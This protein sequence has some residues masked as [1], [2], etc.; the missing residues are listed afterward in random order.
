MSESLLELPNSPVEFEQQLDE[1]LLRDRPALRKM[2]FAVRKRQSKQEPCDQLLARLQKRLTKSQTIVAHKRQHVPSIEFPAN[3][4]VSERRE[5]IA[6]VISRNQVVVLAGET[7]SGKTTQLPKICLELGRG[8]NGLIGHTQP[9]RIAASTVASRIAEELKVELGTAVGYQVR[10]SDNSNEH[11]YIKL[12]TDGIL[13]AEIQNDPLLERYDTLIIDEA[14]E[15]SLNIDFLLGYIKQILPKRPD[16]K[17]I[18]TSATIDLK[19]FSEHFNNAPIVEVSGRT[20]PVEVLYRPWQGEAEDQNQA[21]LEAIEEILTLP[22]Q[23]SGDILVFLSGERDIREAANAIRKADLPHIEVLP[24]YARLSLAEQN[25][26]FQQHR[27]RRIVL[28]TNVA[29][30][31]ITVPGIGYVID[32]GY[33]RISRYSVRTKVQRLPIEPIAQASANQRAGRCGRVSNGVCVRLY[34]E[35][36]YLSRPQFTDAEILR[37]NLASVVLQMLHLGI[38]DIRRF[39]FVDRPDRK[40]ITDGYKLLEELQA[41]NDK[42]QLTKLGRDIAA[43]PLDPRIARMLIEANRQD[44][45]KEVAVIAAAL[46]IQDPRE[47]PAEK[48]QAAD[49]KHRRFWHDNS[50]FLAYLSLWDHVELQR[51]ELSQNQWRKQSSKEFLSFMRLRE[52]RDLHHQIRVACKQIGLQ[53]NKQ[54]AADTAIHKSL[55]SGLLSH[56]GMKSDEQGETVYLGARNRRF[57]IFPGSSQFKKRPK[58]IAAAEM[59]ETSKLYGHTIAR[60]EPEWALELGTHLL[61]HHYYQ[62]HYN[63]KSGQVIGYDRI[64][65]FGLVLAEKKQVN[66]NQ[67]DAAVAREVFIRGALVEGGYSKNPRAKGEFYKHNL[68]QLEAVQTLEA[69]SRRRDILVDD[70]VLY[71]FYD[72]LIPPH[73]NNLAGF[74]HWRKQA[75]KEMPGLLN[76]PRSLLMQHQAADI[77]EAQFPDVLMMD[78]MELPLFYHFEPG[79]A[80][81][82]VSVGVPATILHTVPEHRLDWLVPGLLRDKCIALVKGLPKQWRKQLV[83]VPHFV[84]QALT[85]MK[86]SNTALTEVLQHELSRLLGKPLPNDIWDGIELDAFYRTNIQVLDDRQKVIDR[87]RSL[88]HLREKYRAHVQSTLQSAGESLERERITDWDFGE[89]PKVQTLKKS[90]IQVKAFPALV[91]EQDGLALRMLDNPMDAAAENRRGVV[92]LL[93]TRMAPTIK[94]LHKD[95]LRNKDMALTMVDLG[96]REDVVRDII[97]GATEFACLYGQPTPMDEAAFE[98]ALAR[99]KTEVVRVAQQYEKLLLDTLTRIVQIKKKMKTSKNALALAYASS[100][101]K[102]QLDTLIYRGFI[103]QTPKEWLEQYPRYLDAVDVRLDKVALNVQKDKLAIAAVDRHW[104]RHTARL[105]KEGE[106]GYANNPLWQ[107]YRWMIEELRVSLFAQTLKTKVPVSDK[108]LDKVWADSLG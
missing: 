79:H 13:L 22:R 54:P 78:G 16:L 90:G 53:E 84:D 48:Q 8:I 106:N 37:T 26:V 6:E 35:E 62:P 42:G 56:I 44:A 19:R 101:I 17:V 31:S 68:Q 52:W 30:T 2:W 46:S 95:L 15:R 91:T 5:E 10:F 51:Q 92:H 67:I 102:A 25:R 21:I 94:Y 58:W 70:E 57:H 80:D 40:M 18:I 65:L 83:P 60:I 41:V 50:D 99:G 74:E 85:R 29:E 14:H 11:S 86:P 63:F 76:I 43:L 39:P 36:D 61:K 108:R 55:L 38:G 20:Y 4:P 7:G 66:Y 98:Q 72:E 105:Q 73:V 27:G 49:E 3:L 47:R 89:L 88:P 75:E 12:M 96:K 104:Q 77:T 34:S 69:K 71:R 87:D 1:V 103:A 64:T 28:A 81:D 23:P 24:L 82:G 33:A 45:V 93:A 9:R 32:P 59:L 100:D 97:N 107:Q